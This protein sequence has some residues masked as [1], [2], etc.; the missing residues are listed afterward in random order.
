MARPTI[1]SDSAAWRF[2]V[3]A[4]FVVSTLLTAGGIYMLPADLWT[5]GYLGMGL[6]FT[7]SSAFAL[8]KS[9]RD[10]HEAQRLHHKLDDAEADRILREATV[11]FAA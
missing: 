5:R 6:F 4:A 8:S 2:Q 10:E 11:Q 1:S 3:W 9:V 7:L